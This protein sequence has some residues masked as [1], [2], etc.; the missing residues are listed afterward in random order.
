MDYPLD[1]SIGFQLTKLLREH[2]LGNR[3]DR[4]FHV[5]ESQDLAA[6]E[7]KQDQQLPAAFEKTEGLL[8]TLRSVENEQFDSWSR[9]P[10]S[11]MPQ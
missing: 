8:D 2:L 4:A 1:D 10:P 11:L 7:M 6:E 9:Q 5:G 3:R